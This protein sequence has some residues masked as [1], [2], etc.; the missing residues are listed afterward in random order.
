MAVSAVSS[1]PSISIM[2]G[3]RSETRCCATTAAAGRSG[4]VLKAN[5]FLCG[6]RFNAVEIN[7][8]FRERASQR[9]PSAHQA[10]LNLDERV[11]LARI[12]DKRFGRY[13]HQNLLQSVYIP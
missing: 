13:S 6:E 4:V 9:K 10:G 7:P 3:G 12:S 2:Y 11:I 8:S 1:L 5:V